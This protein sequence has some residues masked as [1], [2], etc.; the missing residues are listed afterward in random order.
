MI[1]DWTDRQCELKAVCT[2]YITLT[3]RV[4]SCGCCYDNWSEKLNSTQLCCTYLTDTVRWLSIVFHIGCCF[5]VIFQSFCGNFMEPPPWHLL[6]WITKCLYNVEQ[7]VWI[8][9]FAWAVLNVRPV[10]QIFE[11]LCYSARVHT[12]FFFRKYIWWHCREG[13]DSPLITSPCKYSDLGLILFLLLWSLVLRFQQTSRGR[14]AT[15][16]DTGIVT[17]IV[18]E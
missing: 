4:D 11:K 6:K 1:N 14:S 9:F 3:A 7:L 18:K 15:V 16:R 8:Q 5:A 13:T 12:S 17:I 10:Q 2:R